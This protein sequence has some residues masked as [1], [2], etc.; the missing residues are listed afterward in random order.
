[1]NFR[2]RQLLDSLSV[3]PNIVTGIYQ[4]YVFSPKPYVVSP[5]LYA[6]AM[7]VSNRYHYKNYKANAIDYKWLRYDLTFQMIATAF[8]SYFTAFGFDG[9]TTILALLYVS[10]Q[11]DLRSTQQR[12]YAYVLN[13]I[14]CF[15]SAGTVL[16]LWLYWS[17]N[18]LIFSINFIYPNTYTH[19]LFHLVANHICQLTW[20]Y[21]FTPYGAHKSL[22]RIRRPHPDL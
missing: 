16:E 6:L 5:L 1:M 11:L 9:L 17:I 22:G 20:D 14:A 18:F 7:L 15:I 12:C 3:I 21:S 19:T 13:A 4:S 8:S 2:K 10:I